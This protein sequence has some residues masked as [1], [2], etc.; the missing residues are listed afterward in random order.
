MPLLLR[1]DLKC[2]HV[3]LFLF[4]TE[5]VIR[6]LIRVARSSFKGGTLGTPFLLR[7]LCLFCCYATALKDYFLVRY[8]FKHDFNSVTKFIIIFILSIL[9]LFCPNLTVRPRNLT[10]KDIS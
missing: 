9:F 3:V 2:Q 8:L 1:G 10:Q 6:E 7:I 5:F 4:R